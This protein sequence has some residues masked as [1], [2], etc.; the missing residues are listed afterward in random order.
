M[1]AA[2]C[3]GLAALAAAGVALP[4]RAQDAPWQLELGAGRESLSRGLAS[5]RQEDAAVR[6][7][8]A[9]GSLAEFNARRTERFGLTDREL[10]TALAWPLDAQ[11]SAQL[12]ATAS[13]THR[14]LPRYSAS[15]AL[16]RQ[17]GDGW[18]AQAG[19]RSTRYE[20]DRANALSLGADKYFGGAAVGEWRAAAQLT[21][22]RLAGAGSSES[23]RLQL[24]RWFGQRTRIGLIAS[25]G[26]EIDNLGQG[27]VLVSDA[28]AL[29]LLARWSPGGAW[30]INGELGR[31]DLGD[32]YRRSGGRL[33]VQLD[34]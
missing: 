16:Q 27:N 10:G 11:W 5:W 3:A 12:A 4:A 23:L 7:R 13:A 19:L 14:V 18:V 17:L 21:L 34:F 31:T 33:G 24:D 1:R 20:R 28:R 15:G 2:A 32:R 8:R 25:A 30:S 26:R 29:V 22:T 6:W 9:P